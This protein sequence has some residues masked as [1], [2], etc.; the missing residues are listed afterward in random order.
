MFRPSWAAPFFRDNQGLAPLAIDCR[1]C[2]G[3]AVFRQNP[4]VLQQSRNRFFSW[5][6]ISY[7]LAPL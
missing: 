7:N 6:L 4:A 1:P 2:W 3:F 5:C